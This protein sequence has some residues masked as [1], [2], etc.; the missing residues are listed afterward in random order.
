[1]LGRGASTGG[2]TAPPLP[3]VGSLLSLFVVVL[4]LFVGRAVRLRPQT[5]P[6]WY[7]SN[8]HRVFRGT[9]FAS[10]SF[11]GDRSRHRRASAESIEDRYVGFEEYFE[12]I[13]FYFVTLYWN[14]E[15]G[16]KIFFLP[17][18]K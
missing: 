7:R 16:K 4:V 14:L 17:L 15:F 9:G 10:T 8:V 11:V 2:T 3:L 13:S 6:N 5:C 12:C 1:M 18:F